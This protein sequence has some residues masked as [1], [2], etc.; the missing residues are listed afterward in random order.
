ME[1][2]SYCN[3][4][5]YCMLNLGLMRGGG[6]PICHPR[7]ARPQDCDLIIIP[8]TPIDH[9]R[10]GWLMAFLCVILAAS[11]MVEADP[12]QYSEY[13]GVNDSNGEFLN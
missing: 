8:E 5:S 6:P 7:S 2:V 9:I 13:P 11:P 4:I 10:P 1:M 12:L 3:G